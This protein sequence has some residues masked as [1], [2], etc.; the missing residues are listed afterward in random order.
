MPLLII[1]CNLPA[2][3]I[4]QNESGNAYSGYHNEFLGM[5]QF[6]YFSTQKCS[7]DIS[8]AGRE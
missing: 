2:E 6:D 5:M 3:N 1:K 7:S 4:S 8:F